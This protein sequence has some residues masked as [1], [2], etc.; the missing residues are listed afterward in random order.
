MNDTRITY[1]SLL[2]DIAALG[3]RDGV[4]LIAFS[5]GVDSSLVA[6]A[7]FD[8]FPENSEAVMALSP[9]VSRA[10]REQAATIAALIGIPLR[11]VQTAEHRDPTYIANDGMSCYICK[12]HIYA[13]MIAVEED[14]ERRPGRVVLFSG[15]NAE[16]MQ[17]PTRVGIRA[18]REHAVCSPLER[19][20]KADVRALSRHAGLPNWQAAAS[21][22][23]RSRLQA[24]VPA[25]AEHLH[26]IEEAEK[27]LRLLFG[28][29]ED[30]NFRVRQ[31]PGDEAM[32]EIDAPLLERIDLAHCRDL[33]LPLGFAAVGKRAFRSGSVSTVPPESSPQ[34]A[35]SS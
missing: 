29:A 18:A 1:E 16:D 9:S 24:G 14:A 17:D 6:R 19:F 21:P 3:T 5:G 34:Q 32:V 31:L 26:R 33:L 28:L 7:V 25:T 15:N 12:T 13:A 8:V 23:L 20:S 4:N 2:S 22:C 10:M 35:S 30:V 11:T 27:R